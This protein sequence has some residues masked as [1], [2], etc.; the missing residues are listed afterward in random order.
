MSMQTNSVHDLVGFSPDD[1]APIMFARQRLE[2]AAISYAA[3]SVGSQ[4]E[5]F[6]AANIELDRA[7]RAFCVALM[8]AGVIVM[9]AGFETRGHGLDK[10][11][12]HAP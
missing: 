2:R 5:A 9:P 10:E 3:K 1:T 6:I 11:V 8:D 7:S 4:I 12:G